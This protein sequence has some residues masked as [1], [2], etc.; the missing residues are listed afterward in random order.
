MRRRNP[1]AKED[2][3]Q[4]LLPHANDH[5]EELIAEFA[6]ESDDHGLQCWLL[7]LIGETRSPLAL[8]VLIDQLRGEDEALR[9]WAVRGLRL[10]DSK[11]AREA[12]WQARCN[13]VIGDD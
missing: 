13:G 9:D 5:I 4:L 11:P 8:P 2:G 10:L 12:L 6:A 1:Q 3:F 7:E